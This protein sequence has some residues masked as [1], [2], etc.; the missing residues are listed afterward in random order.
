VEVGGGFGAVGYNNTFSGT[1]RQVS[2]W[3]TVLSSSDVTDLWNAGRGYPG[4]LPGPRMARR[5]AP[6][7]PAGTANIPA[8]RLSTGRSTLGPSSRPE[9]TSALEDV[10][11]L[12]L[13][14]M[15][16]VWIGPDGALVLES[17]DDRFL[18]LTSSQTFGEDLANGEC[19]YGDGILHDF[20]PL[21]VYG[22]VKV[23]QS[24]GT[25]AIGGRSTDVAT[26]NAQ[27]FA[28]AYTS[29]STLDLLT[30][31]MTQDYADWVFYSHS[32]PS[33]RIDSITIDPMSNP[34]LWP[35]VYN[36]EIGNRVTVKRRPQ[37]LAGPVVYSSQ[38]FIEQ[39]L[40]SEINFDTSDDQVL[41]WKTTLSLTPTSPVAQPW[42]LDDPT[43]SVLGSTTRLGV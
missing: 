3:N 11:R 16:T 5:L 23:Q 10:Q 26:A 39:V 31:S 25:T 38:Y 2:V 20:D 8:S 7:Y 35:I 4:E 33:Q 1:I 30:G 19:P 12:A 14:E 15:G 21:Y 17:R 40:H 36:A 6:Q 32:V 27:Y 18:R 9:R 42:L 34:A 28:R 22:D 24:S 37:G 43:W 41:S 13:E 29:P